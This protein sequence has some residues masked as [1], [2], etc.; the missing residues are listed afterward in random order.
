MRVRANGPEPK[1][2]TKNGPKTKCALTTIPQW[3]SKKRV[4]ESTFLGQKWVN[5]DKNSKFTH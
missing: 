3:F 5:P 1:I 4:W 2:Q